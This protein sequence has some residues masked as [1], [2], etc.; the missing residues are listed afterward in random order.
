MTAAVDPNSRLTV[1]EQPMSSTSQ[2]E[3]FDLDRFIEAQASV[4]DTALA[5]LRAGRKRTHWIWYILPQLRGLGTSQMST[6]Y[7][8][9]S[10]GEARA[11]LAH[12][13]LG[14]RLRECVRTLNALRE[15]DPVA[16]LGGIDAQKLRSCLTVFAVA[17]SE[18]PLFRAGLEKYFRGQPDA[19]TLSLIERS[20]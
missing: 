14:L 7:G 10:L 9:Q 5:E 12:P 6:R 16:V 11:Y 15:S 18:E 17:S 13:V 4:Y 2:G 3:P 20:G 8:L 19:A 1:I